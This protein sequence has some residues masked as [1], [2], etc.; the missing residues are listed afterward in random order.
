MQKRFWPTFRIADHSGID[1]P[2][3]ESVR[4]AYTRICVCDVAMYT[5]RVV[6]LD[7]V[8]SSSA[9]PQLIPTQ[10]ICAERLGRCRLRA[11]S[12][13]LNRARSESLRL[14]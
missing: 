1:H 6:I 5:P 10:L 13:T 3:D 11:F 4:S 12:S 7:E 14:G 2:Q 9:Q 8:G